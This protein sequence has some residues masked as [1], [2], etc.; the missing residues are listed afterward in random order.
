MSE[1]ATLRFPSLIDLVDAIIER[2]TQ[3]YPDAYC[4]MSDEVY[5]DEDIDLEIYVPEETLLE[6]DKFAH[7]VAFELTNDANVFILPMVVS[8]ECCPVKQ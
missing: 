7:K 1:Q 6:V 2:I 8:M 4:L 3:K 5:G